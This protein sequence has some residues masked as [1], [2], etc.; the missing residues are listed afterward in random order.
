[1][2]FLFTDMEEQTS[3]IPD[4]NASEADNAASFAAH[5]AKS[6]ALAVEMSRE[7]HLE[8]AIQKTAAQTKQALLDG[9]KEVFGYGDERQGS[10]QMSILVRRIPLICQDVKQ[11]HVDISDIKGNIKWGVRLVIGSL[12]T[13]LV[14]ALITM[15]RFHA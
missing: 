14:A 7:I 1:M 12:V 2:Y 6:A 5:K 4:P 10:E 11:I 8:E 3:F 13:A 15:I 9:L